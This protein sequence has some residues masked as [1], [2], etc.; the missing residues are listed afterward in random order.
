[1]QS[2]TQTG[3]PKSGTARLLINN[4]G[5]LGI[6]G[7]PNTFSNYTYL[8]VTGRSNTL[9]G[10]IYLKT[11]ND[12]TN[13]QLIV[14]STAASIVSNSTIPMVFGTGGAEKMRLNS[15][16]ALLINTTT[17]L[18][19][20]FQV[21]GTSR[22]EGNVILSDT[23]NFVF[24]TTTGT[25]IGTATNQRL[26]FWNKTPIVQPTNAIGA[27]AFVANTSGIANDTATYGGYTMGQIAQALINVGILA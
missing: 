18:G 17:D 14:S 24:Q 12:S 26:A 8:T 3:S 16:G 6:N 22:F 10:I 5:D 11:L 21:S 1:M 7:A 20:K 15:A 13:F 19:S 2:T 25:R 9:G 23:V 27:G 4:L